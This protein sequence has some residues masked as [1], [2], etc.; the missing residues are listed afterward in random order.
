[1]VRKQGSSHDDDEDNEYYTGI[2][3]TMP[4]TGIMVPI[5]RAVQGIGFGV[6][7]EMGGGGGRE[8]GDSTERVVG[9]GKGGHGW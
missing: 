9:R 5:G 8:E 1:M 3:I 4:R 6:R 7:E 2:M